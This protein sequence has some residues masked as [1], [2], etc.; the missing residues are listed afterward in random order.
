[1]YKWRNTTKWYVDKDKIVS[2]SKSSL[3]TEELFDLLSLYMVI[4]GGD[5]PRIIAIA[6]VCFIIY[7]SWNLNDYILYLATY[8]F[9]VAF[10]PYFLFCRVDN[11]KD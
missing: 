7:L 2:L 11:W 3:K 4:E 6:L 9:N 1:M 8:D 10:H 5:Y